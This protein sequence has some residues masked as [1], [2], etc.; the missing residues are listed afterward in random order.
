MGLSVKVKKKTRKSVSNSIEL[1]LMGSEPRFLPGTVVEPSKMADAYNWYNVFYDY[2]MSR[3]FLVDYMKENKFDKDSIHRVASLPTAFHPPTIG[4][5][6]RI[7]SRGATINDTSKSWFDANLKDVIDVSRKKF[8]A[9]GSLEQELIRPVS[10][11]DRLRAQFENVVADIDDQIDMFFDDVSHTF[12]VKEY[13]SKR[14]LSGVVAKKAANHFSR[15]LKEYD[16]VLVK[17]DEQAVEAYRNISKPKLKKMREFLYEIVVALGAESHKAKIIRAPRRPKQKSTSQLV[18]KMKY[19]SHF[20]DLDLI[21]VAPEGIIGATQ[22]WVYNPK[23][24][25]LGVYQAE[26]ASG[27]KVKRSSIVGFDQKTSISKK[28]RK[29]EK[30]LPVVTQGGKVA[31]R[32]V[33]DNINAVPSQLTGRISSDTILLRTV[34]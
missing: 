33:L 25:K 20:K 15:L 31:L 4:W 22:L 17:K 7:L 24:R 3:K 9:S 5:V 28:L 30:V 12:N 27:L 6:A 23:A 19:M 8:L 16:D 1:Q 2:A 34:K 32:S 29:P 18:S 13:I 10:I 26:G 14:S 11:Q 21:S